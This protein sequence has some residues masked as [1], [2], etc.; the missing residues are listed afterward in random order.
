[1][2]SKSSVS[3]GHAAVGGVIYDAVPLIPIDVFDRHG[4]RDLE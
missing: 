3:V 4:H 1:M 2:A